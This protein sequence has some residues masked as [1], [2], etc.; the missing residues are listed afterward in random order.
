MVN[1]Q[2]F[3][4]LEAKPLPASRG[5]K[6]GASAQAIVAEPIPSESV[7]RHITG[8]PPMKTSVRLPSTKS[9]SASVPSASVPSAS[10]PS[11]CPNPGAMSRAETL[12]QL[13]AQLEQKNGS[14]SVSNETLST[15]CQQID[16]WLPRGG[17]RCDAITEWVAEGEGCGASTLS[18]LTAAMRLSQ[19]ESS[20]GPL[21]VVSGPASGSRAGFYPPAGKALGVPMERLIWVRPKQH[22]D[23]VWAV[24]QA[25]RCRSVAAV[26]AEIGA[27]LDDRD[28]RR[29][30]LA[31]EKGGTPGLFVRPAAVRGRPSFAEVRFQVAP[32]VSDTDH[33]DL[34]GGGDRLMQITLDRC[35]G[36]KV[37]Q[38]A[39]VR[40]D[41][42]AR[43]Q[44]ITLPSSGTA[45]DDTT[46]LPLAAEL[47]HPKSSSR[48]IHRRRA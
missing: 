6:L 40:L 28:A 14:A 25:L 7:S 12:R 15:G 27:S 30:Q 20:G 41:D 32:L 22:A 45:S 33:C 44:S 39:W 5:R 18:L 48:A 21:V 1:Q 8:P 46:I 35:R 29:F 11:E 26:W 19:A 37:G 23:L 4:F 17:L 24:D 2:T 16:D 38:Q 43:L 13:R 47:A 42:R 34:S 9:P 10:L 36:G 3:D 31:A